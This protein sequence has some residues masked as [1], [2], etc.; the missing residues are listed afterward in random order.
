MIMNV[1]FVTMRKIIP[2][3]DG[4]TIYSYGILRYLKEL[5]AKT[6]FVSFYEK[7][8]YT[9][10]EKDK[11]LKYCESVFSVKLNWQSTALNL[12]FKYPN[13][14]R[15]YTRSSMK[16][17]LRDIKDKKEFDIVVIDHLQMFEYAKIFDNAKIVLIEHNIESNIWS[18]YAGKCK[19]IVKL[20]VKRSADMTL[21]YEKEAVKSADAIIS[22]AETDA[23]TLKSFDENAVVEVMHPYNVYELV[24]DKEDIEKIDN[25]ILFI[26][27]YSWYP[28]QK[29]ADFLVN[30]VMPE[31]RK[32]ISGI[33]LYLVGKDPTEKIKEYG[34]IYDDVIV[35]GMVDSIDPYIKKCD[36]FVNAM[37][38]GSGM[39]IKM[40]EAMGKGI[41]ILSSLYGCRGINISNLQEAFVFGSADECI[42]Y[43]CELINNRETAVSL[44]ENARKFY[45]DFIKPDDKVRNIFDVL[46]G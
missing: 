31:L 26:G 11:L 13:N 37:F 36:I 27:S 32:K 28:N 43:I 20:L 5:G 21:K 16:K 17:I 22:I 19:G 38:E 39:N 15:K 6:D 45:L 7:G 40:I 8:D 3:N 44:S 2:L 33:K 23:K 34:E 42:C 9:D 25:S 46:E 10:D 35:T 41:P 18:E 24:K 4:A 1:L 12:S 30:D 29:A 14:I